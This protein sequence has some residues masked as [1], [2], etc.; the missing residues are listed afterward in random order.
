M[1]KK[2]LELQSEVSKDLN[3]L[4]N[5]VFSNEDYELKLINLIRSVKFVTDGISEKVDLINS[6]K[7]G[8]NKER[9]LN[10]INE[11]CF[12]IGTLCDTIEEKLNSSDFIAL[13]NLIYNQKQI[14]LINN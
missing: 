8:K 10:D 4:L 5:S 3:N 7:T 12:S 11:K 13:Y 14:T 2:K 9:L 1:E 6:G